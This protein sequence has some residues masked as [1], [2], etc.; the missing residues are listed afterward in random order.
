MLLVRVMHPI[1]TITS[2]GR[3]KPVIPGLVFGTARAAGN[4]KTFFED[5]SEKE[6]SLI[7]G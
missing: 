1:L 3:I 6:V 5:E 4:E 7:S 2:P